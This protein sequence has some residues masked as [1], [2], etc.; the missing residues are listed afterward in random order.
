MDMSDTQVFINP[1]YLIVSNM[2][3]IPQLLNTCEAQRMIKCKHLLRVLIKHYILI[4]LKFVFYELLLH[5]LQ[6]DKN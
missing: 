6:M 4:Q 2:K 3:T 1:R 5:E